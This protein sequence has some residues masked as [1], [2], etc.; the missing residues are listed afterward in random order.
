MGKEKFIYNERSLQFEKYKPSFGK[1]LRLFL[2]YTLLV[3]IVAAGIMYVQIQYFPSAN[4]VSLSRELDQMK[5][6]YAG[7]NEQFDKLDKV[8]SNIQDR[9]ANVHRM[10]F[11][12]DPIDEDVWQAGV[13]GHERYAEVIDFKNSGALLKKT[14]ER[15][16]RLAH[17]LTLQSK[18]L[19]SLEFLAG[20]KEDYIRSVPSIKPV[21]EDKLK[22]RITQLSGY[23][24]RLHP[25]HKIMKMH[26]GLDFTAPTGTEIQATG[27]GKV[28]KVKNS[29]SGYGKHIV[30]DHGYGYKT[31]YAHLSDVRVEV[32]Q[33][34]EKG[35]LIGAIGSTGTSTAPHLHYEVRFNN[36]PINPI[37]FCMD[38]LSP[39][40]YKELVN[41]ASQTNKSLD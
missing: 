7:L 24:M 16:D 40:E 14:L 25:V 33:K 10:I 20:E 11:G 8:L 4:E 34:V 29:R 15:A 17:Q 2:A 21:R 37:H 9:D 26:Q 36:N 3:L 19:D 27:N 41:M 28:V 1:R 6:K 18:S 30:I 38:G 35:E 13:G 22:R 39:D 23:G 31:L 12:M 32:G 5:I